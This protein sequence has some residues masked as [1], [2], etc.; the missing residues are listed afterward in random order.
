MKSFRTNKLRFLTRCFC[1]NGGRKIAI[2]LRRKDEVKKLRLFVRRSLEFRAS[3]N[4]S[5]AV[6]DVSGQGV[7]E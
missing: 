7:R 5:A 4:L 1:A 6:F 3:K 2:R